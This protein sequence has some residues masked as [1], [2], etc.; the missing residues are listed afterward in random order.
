MFCVFVAYFQCTFKIYV[1]NLELT[2]IGHYFEEGGGGVQSQIL[3]KIDPNIF[4]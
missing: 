2:K 1:N 3:K 4:S